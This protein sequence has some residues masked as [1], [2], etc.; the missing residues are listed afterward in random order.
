MDTTAQASLD[1]CLALIR[2]LGRAHGLEEV[3]SAALAALGDGLGVTR[4]SILFFD[5]AGVMRFAAWRGL[6]DTYRQAVEGHSPWHVGD[7]EVAPIIVED[8]LDDDSLI[9]L[10]PVF[11]AEGIRG[12]AFFPLCSGGGVIGK[13]MLYSETPR[14]FAAS[15]VQLGALIASQVA[16]AVERITAEDR[17]RR[18]EQRLR[19]ALDAASMGTW[20]WDLQT[21]EVEWSDNLAPLHGLPPGAFDGTFASYE[22]E[23]HPDDRQR[24]LDTA[25]RALTGDVPYDVEYRL[26]GPDGVV[27]WVEGKGRV[28]H[29]DGQPTRM[30]GV[31]IMATRRKEA[32]LARLASAE[33]A[34][35]MKDEFLA[36]LSHELRTPL[37]AI[38]GWVE[39]LQGGSLPPARAAQAVETIGRNARLQA[40]LIEDILD[41]SRIITGKL[42]L[43]RLPVSLA[44]LV[45]TAITAIGP[46]A[47]QKGVALACSMGEDLPPITG[48][49]RRLQ[50]VLGNILS[51]AVKFTPRGGRV[52][53]RCERHGSL[54]W[55]DVEDTGAGIDPAFL[56]YVFERFRQADSR[57]TRQYGGL[58]LGLAIARH[59]VEQHGGTI[60]AESD[61]PGS[62][63]RVRV[64][65]P[66]LNSAETDRQGPAAGA[67]APVVDASLSGAQVMVVDDDE[68]SRHLVVAVFESV[69]CRV[70]VC[71]SAAAGL[72]AADTSPPHL[73]VADIAM[74]GVDGYAMMTRLRAAHPL[75]P[76][77]AVSAHARLEDRNRA[78]DAGFDAY[79]TKPIDAARL[80]DDARSLLRGRLRHA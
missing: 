72:K 75:V 63:T 12:L 26:I 42:E 23:I 11:E 78:F 43:D 71:D 8:V 55:M 67:Y 73:V 2:S 35:R 53:L 65:L 74:P 24:V 13:F 21:N 10:R 79:H 70:V 77:I 64:Q 38:I 20:E 52:T 46:S 60:S 29:V 18:S 5:S 56:P 15:E 62:G 27:R 4:S 36:T 69:G 16:F 48:D 51:N 37:N 25:R 34:S 17:I 31:C 19:F 22:R 1:V 80:L 7:T 45:D 54:V 49:P 39:L 66:A 61:G 6:S 33:E 50:Q 41:V 40:H 32:E 14:P 68:D 30:S 59:L 44:Q 3:H 57:T 58:G 76:S 28:E 47:Q 9:A